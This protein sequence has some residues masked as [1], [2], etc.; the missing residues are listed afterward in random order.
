MSYTM[1]L[2]PKEYSLFV[3]LIYQTSGI[4]LGE[5]KQELLK[6]RFQKIMHR[7]GICS[8]RDYYSYVIDG[9]NKGAFGEMIDAISTN[10]TFFARENAHFDFLQKT[11]LAEI[12]SRKSQSKTYTM[13][14]WCAASSSGEEPYTIMIALLESM[15]VNRWDI[16]LL[17]TDISTQILKQAMDGMYHH[18]KVRDLS[19]LWVEKYFVREKVEKDIWCRVVPEV[20]QYIAFRHFNLM[21]SP[22]PFKGKF[23]FIFCRNVMIYFDEKTQQH[24][25]KKMSHCL[26]DGGYLFIGHSENIP[27]QSQ[28]QAYL[29]PVR[30]AVFKKVV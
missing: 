8:Y 17:A 1:K 9:G 24:L 6:T 26:A 5:N 2:S 21:T 4:S 30:P 27:L 18:S 7:L 14:G 28:A 13:R 19:P 3:E 29:R 23:D 25:V 16:K 15:D 22:F 20:K 11:A 12:V 10:H